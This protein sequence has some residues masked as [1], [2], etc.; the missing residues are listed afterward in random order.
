[1]VRSR[2]RSNQV[3]PIQV[4]IIRGGFAA[5][6]FAKTLR[7]KLRPSDCEILLFNRENHMVFHPL[8]AG[9]PCFA[10]AF[11]YNN[12]LSKRRRLYEHRSPG[13]KSMGT[14]TM[15]QMQY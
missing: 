13:G 4:V 11:C 12:C 9:E 15:R 8:L 7:G 6:T 2:H 10:S 3:K 14:M 1:M 5:V